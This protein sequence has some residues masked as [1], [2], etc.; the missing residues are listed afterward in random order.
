[1]RDCR[2]VRLFQSVAEEE[3]A[4]FGAALGETPE[5]CAQSDDRGFPSVRPRP[6]QVQQSESPA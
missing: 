1:M 2:G 5:I 3:V 4:E 6:P